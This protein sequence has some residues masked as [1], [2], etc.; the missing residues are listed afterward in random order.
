MIAGI[1]R[2]AVALLVV[3]GATTGCQGPSDGG[4][5]PCA[6]AA[7]VGCAPHV[8]FG[9]TVRV[10][11]QEWQAQR[12]RTRKT[13][14]GP[15]FLGA[16]ARG[17]FVIITMRTIS[18][19][20]A[21]LSSRTFQLEIDGKAYGPDDVGFSAAAGEDAFYLIAKIK[22]GVITTVKAVFDVPVSALS[23]KAEMRFNEPGL[24]P[25]GSRHGYIDISSRLG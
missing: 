20:D 9:G 17:R 21:T 24:A 25:S 6:R 2:R 15:R 14:G 16:R 5:A 13:I 7:T 18:A 23:K 4:S 22:V 8:A 19:R 1:C 3:V 11:E 12:V 10:G